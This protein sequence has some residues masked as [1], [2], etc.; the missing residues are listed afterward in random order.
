MTVVRNLEYGR[1]GDRPLRLDIYLP[2]KPV[3]KV[4]ALV[5]IHGG[6]WSSGGKDF[7]PINFMARS[8]MAI[9]SINYR[10]T[11]V[12]AFPSPAL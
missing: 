6:S 9:V 2:L 12:A 8:N 3:G 11:D 4:P 10:L 1:V 7:C 5:W